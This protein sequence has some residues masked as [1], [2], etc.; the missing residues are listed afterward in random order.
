MLSPYSLSIHSPVV[1]ESPLSSGKALTLGK[2]YKVSIRLEEEHLLPHP[3]ATN[4]TD[5]DALW[6]KND[7][8]GPRSQQMCIY[9][10]LRK[11]NKQCSGCEGQEMMHED[12]HRLCKNQAVEFAL[13]VEKLIQIVFPNANITIQKE[14]NMAHD[15]VWWQ[16]IVFCCPVPFLDCGNNDD[17]AWRQPIVFLLSD[18]FLVL[19]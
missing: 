8:T 3:Y 2:Q 19:W 18:S 5:Y 16:P 13:R 7:K 11:Y 9:M 12:K 17:L 14:S 4:C 10:C 15:L 1:P 6:R